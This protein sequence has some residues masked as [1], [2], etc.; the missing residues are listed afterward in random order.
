MSYFEDLPILWVNNW[1]TD[2][3]DEV[4]LEE[5]YEEIME[6]EYDLL[7]LTLSYWADKIIKSATE[8]DRK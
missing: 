7:P 4:F 5:K 8:E 3:L 1:L 2:V 6:K